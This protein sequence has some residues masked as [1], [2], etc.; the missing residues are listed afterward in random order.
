MPW[1]EPLNF[2]SRSSFPFYPGISDRQL[3][4]IGMVSVQWALV[5]LQM[6]EH[7]LRF[8]SYDAEL[9]DKYARQQSFRHKRQFWQKQIEAKVVGERRNELLRLVEQNRAKVKRDRV[10]HGPWA[11]G[12]QSGTWASEDYPTSDAQISRGTHKGAP[13]KW[14]L[15]FQGL[16]RIG[17][18]IAILN[19]T[20]FRLLDPSI[21]P[22]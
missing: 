10:M 19:V 5:E 7:T 2:P 9:A 1:I 6:H 4:A 13:P 14:S 12:M 11:G 8:T 20:M 21:E 17:R 18:E 15:D 3:W 22:Y 16:R